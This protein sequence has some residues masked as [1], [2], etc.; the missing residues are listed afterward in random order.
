MGLLSGTGIALAMIGLLVAFVMLILRAAG[1]A[2][3]IKTGKFGKASR[4]AK[5]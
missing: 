2:H 5:S 3:M 4:L 1:I